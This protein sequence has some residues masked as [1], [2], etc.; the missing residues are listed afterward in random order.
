MWLTLNNRWTWIQKFACSLITTRYKFNVLL[1]FL[2]HTSNDAKLPAMT[3]SSTN[4][5]LKRTRVH[6]E[7]TS[8]DPGKVSWESTRLSSSRVIFKIGLQFYSLLWLLGGLIVS[9]LVL[10]SVRVRGLYVQVLLL[11]TS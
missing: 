9:I 11:C 5:S 3:A 6:L 4:F 10:F 1:Q 8:S 2:S 7:R